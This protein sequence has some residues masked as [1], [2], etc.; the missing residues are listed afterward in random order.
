M[1]NFFK[2]KEPAIKLEDLKLEDIGIRL[3]ETIFEL[4]NNG[5]F[6]K[7]LVQTVYKTYRT[8]DFMRFGKMNFLDKA[9]M[10]SNVIDTTKT[11][12]A[13]YNFTNEKLDGLYE[14]IVRLLISVKD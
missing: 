13:K 14:E 8:Q 10:L 4:S 9:V 7:D 11:V 6:S 3:S 12:S 5:A 2:K 1:F